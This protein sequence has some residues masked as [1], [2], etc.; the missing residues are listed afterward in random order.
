MKAVLLDKP[1]PIEETPLRYSEY[2]VPTIADDEILIKIK[3]CGVCRS[4]LNV[5]EGVYSRLGIPSLSPIIPGHEIIGLI[6]ET[7]S[8]VKNLVAGDR[9]GIQ[10]LYS[11]CGICEYCLS[12]REHLCPN[13]LEKITTYIVFPRNSKIM[14]R[15]HSFVLESLPTEP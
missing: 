6:T 2:D 10:P 7:G 5:I 11:A 1:A 8:N 12:A 9:V 4:N 3:A 14:K 15:L 13:R